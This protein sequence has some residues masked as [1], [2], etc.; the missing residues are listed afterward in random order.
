[1]ITN[2]T[3]HYFKIAAFILEFNHIPKNHGL[4]WSP[5]EDDAIHLSLIAKQ[6]D[7]SFSNIL[8]LNYGKN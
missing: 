6:M 2:K 1:M 3:E 4:V 5:V 8:L 7:E